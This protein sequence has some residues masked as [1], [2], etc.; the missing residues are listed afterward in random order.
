MR[1]APDFHFPPPERG[2]RHRGL[3]LGASLVA[4]VG[5][6]VLVSVGTRSFTDRG[7]VEHVLLFTPPTGTVRE[8]TLPGW[9]GGGGAPRLLLPDPGQR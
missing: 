3:A 1:P 2:P 8:A 6:V 5:L 9:T 7:P 4:H